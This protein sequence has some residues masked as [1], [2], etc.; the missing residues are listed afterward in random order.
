MHGLAFNSM[1][2]QFKSMFLILLEDVLSQDNKLWITDHE[3]HDNLFDFFKSNW[4]FIEQLTL[5]LIPPS[6][7]FF[8]INLAGSSSVTQQGQ[9]TQWT[10]DII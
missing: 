10:V 8:A 1:H 6:Y 9:S 2:Q 5:T 7:V 4:C 3:S